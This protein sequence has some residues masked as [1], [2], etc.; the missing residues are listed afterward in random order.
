MNEPYGYDEGQMEMLAGMIR[1][2]PD[3]YRVLIFTHISPE[4]DVTAWGE[5]IRNNRALRDLVAKEIRAGR[6]ICIIHGHDHS[7]TVKDVNGIP[8]VGI[9]CSAL[10]D[11]K[12]KRPLADGRFGRIPRTPSEELTDI[13]ILRNDSDVLKFVRIGAGENRDVDINR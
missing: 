6:K 10:E 1:K 11:H 2:A 13:L 4:N 5:V 8:V 9:G 7:D 12:G 3:G